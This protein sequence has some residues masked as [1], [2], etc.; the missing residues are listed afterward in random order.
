M[1]KVWQRFWSLFVLGTPLLLLSAGCG[2]NDVPI[3]GGSGV[4]EGGSSNTGNRG[5][6]GNVA[7]SGNFG[8]VGNS[9]GYGNVGNNGGYGN[10][11]GFV[12]T[13]GAA[14]TCGD[15]RCNFGE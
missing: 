12:G 9:G 10:F 5:G 2:R 3:Y 11:A 14:G 6:F 13:A 7:G 1:A 4:A 8:N 15:G